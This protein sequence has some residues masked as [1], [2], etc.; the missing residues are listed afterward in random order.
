MPKNSEIVENMYEAGR[1]IVKKK[2]KIASNPPRLQEHQ[3]KKGDITQGY[4]INDNVLGEKDYEAG[5][6]IGE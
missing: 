6:D 3:K 1:Q 2:K 5:N 4:R